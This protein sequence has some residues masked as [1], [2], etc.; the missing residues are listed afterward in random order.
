[1]AWPFKIMEWPCF[2]FQLRSVK[3]NHAYIIIGKP[4]PSHE[5]LQYGTCISRVQCGYHALDGHLRS[6]LSAWDW[7]VSF[8]L[9]LNWSMWEGVSYIGIS[10]WPSL[11]HLRYFLYLQAAVY[12]RGNGIPLVN[13]IPQ[14]N[15]CRT[16]C[17]VRGLQFQKRTVPGSHKFVCVIL[18]N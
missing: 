11:Q 14:W 8:S 9:C 1:M 7:D 10:Y 3:L 15:G 4:P 18:T 12:Q 6:S 2:C 5:V 17:G 16:G 13:T